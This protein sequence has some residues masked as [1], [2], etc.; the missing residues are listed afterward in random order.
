MK[1]EEKEKEKTNKT[2]HKACWDLLRVM[3]KLLWDVLGFD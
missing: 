3:E 1:T 2:Q